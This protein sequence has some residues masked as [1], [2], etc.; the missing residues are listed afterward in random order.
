MLILPLGSV[1]SWLKGAEPQGERFHI[2]PRTLVHLDHVGN[3]AAV[4]SGQLGLCVLYHCLQRLGRC[5]MSTNNLIT[6]WKRIW[7][8]LMG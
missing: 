8:H 7:R 5:L 3:L 4:E 2:A 6:T 1:Y